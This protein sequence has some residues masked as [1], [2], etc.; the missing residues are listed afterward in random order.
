MIFTNSAG[1]PTHNAVS[2]RHGWGLDRSDGRAINIPIHS[3]TLD[4][5]DKIESRNGGIL[6]QTRCGQRRKIVEKNHC[7]L[8]TLNANMP[9]FFGFLGLGI[10]IANEVRT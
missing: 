5:T 2:S 10:T 4:A 6:Q 7:V 9:E 1:R 3:R 8:N